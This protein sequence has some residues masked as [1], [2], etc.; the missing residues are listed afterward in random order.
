M[1]QQIENNTPPSYS[2][3][4]MSRSQMNQVVDTLKNYKFAYLARIIYLINTAYLLFNYLLF[5]YSFF[6]KNK[7]LNVYSRLR[8]NATRHFFIGIYILGSH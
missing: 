5:C 4:N 7:N 3:L 8:A 6:K 1:H 2:C